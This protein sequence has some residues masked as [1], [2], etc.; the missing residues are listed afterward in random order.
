ME[1]KFT[2]GNWSIVKDKHG[3]SEDDRIIA[4]IDNGSEDRRLLICS[5]DLGGFHYAN[6]CVLS[7]AGDMYSALDKLVTRLMRMGLSGNSR[8]LSKA[9]KALA[10]ARGEQP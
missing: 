1:T 5:D 9:L 6:A 4:I 7:A 10:K 2:K 3:T 8:E